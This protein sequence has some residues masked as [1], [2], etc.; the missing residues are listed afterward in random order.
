VN[1]GVIYIYDD[2]STFKRLNRPYSK[3]EIN[4][5]EEKMELVLDPKKLMD[6]N[7]TISSFPKEGLDYQCEFYLDPHL[8]DEVIKIKKENYQSY[9]GNNI[10]FRESEKFDIVVH[11][12]TFEGVFLHHKLICLM[13]K[14]LL[15]VPNDK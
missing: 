10:E 11:F 1:N 14:G 7:L 9:L 2:F 3:E 4:K 12:K 6:S 8:R 15:N 5:Y 13:L